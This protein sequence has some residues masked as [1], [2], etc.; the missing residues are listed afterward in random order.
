MCL[1][2][3]SI[4]NDF[5]YCFNHKQRVSI[6]AVKHSKNCLICGG[7]ITISKEKKSFTY[8]LPRQPDLQEKLLIEVIRHLPKKLFDKVVDKIVKAIDSK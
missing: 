4:N 5:Y 3:K 1:Y 2:Y 6:E 8:E 7:K